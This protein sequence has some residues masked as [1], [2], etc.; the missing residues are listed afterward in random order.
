VGRTRGRNREAAE[1]FTAAQQLYAEI[2]DRLG[3][4]NALKNLG[5]VRYQQGAYDA[6]IS[7][8]TSAL[9]LYVDGEHRL[10]KANT[11]HE[12]GVAHLMKGDLDSAT[13]ALTAA[14]QAYIEVDAQ[15]GQATSIK[16]LGVALR[17][18][19][20]YPESAEKLTTAHERLSA[21]GVRDDEID[22]LN[23]LGDLALDYPPAGDPRDYFGRALELAREHG[24]QLHEA[25]ALTGQARS[26]IATDPAAAVPLL[27]EAHAIYRSYEAPQADSLA[28]TLD[29][30][31]SR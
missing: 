21:I 17:L 18:A 10:G 15:L 9:H 26:L 14:H 19:G 28:A 2:G 12:L 4:A 11:V 3:Q 27:R 6:A 25:R 16:N 7:T 13:R 5:T 23:D 8:L 29:H 24:L 31:P 1:L 30:A 22:A 20:S